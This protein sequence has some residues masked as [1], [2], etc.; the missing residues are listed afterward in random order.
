MVLDP[1][2]VI[3]CV[4]HKSTQLLLVA[5]LVRP[6]CDN[7]ADVC[8][9]HSA[10]L[11][12]IVHQMRYDKILPHPEAR[13][14]ADYER[15]GISGLDALI[16]RLAPDR[17]IERVPQRCPDVLYRLH[18]TAVQLAEDIA[19][20]Q[21]KRHCTVTVSKLIIIHAYPTHTAYSQLK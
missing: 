16:Q 10:A 3:Y 14:I 11:G 5:A 9:P 7:N 19:A 20:L 4:G 1:Y 13:H 15:D 12:E 18:L 17:L 6:V 21:R 8:I 2:A